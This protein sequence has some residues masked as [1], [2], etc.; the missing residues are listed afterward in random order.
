MDQEKIIGIIDLSPFDIAPV[1]VW[2]S[3][4]TQEKLLTK[5]SVQQGSAMEE[6]LC[7]SVNDF[8]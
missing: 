1:C 8:L 7:M 2:R 4:G 3:L 6:D 5:R